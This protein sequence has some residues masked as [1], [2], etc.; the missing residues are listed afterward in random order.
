[1]S[2]LRSK[3]RYLLT[4]CEELV[5]DKTLD[6]GLSQEDENEMYDMYSH[7]KQNHFVQKQ[8]KIFLR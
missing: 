8:A 1:M 3:P 4:T 6:F 5:F 7:S 2:T